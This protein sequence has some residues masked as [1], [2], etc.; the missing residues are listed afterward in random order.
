MSPTTSI[1]V[2]L[3]IV[4]DSEGRLQLPKLTSVNY[5]PW[6]FTI[7]AVL[8]GKD[9]SQHIDKDVDDL[10]NARQESCQG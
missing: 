6:S 7:K 5:R 8:A 2:P 1:V 10:I 3:S 9:L 4:M